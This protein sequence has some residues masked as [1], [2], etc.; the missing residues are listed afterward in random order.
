VGRL[1]RTGTGDGAGGTGG[2]GGPAAYPCEGR[3][4]CEDFEDVPVG[5]APGAPWEALEIKG[6]V[7]V[8]D[9]RAFSG[10][11]SLQVSIQATAPDENTYRRA[12][13]AISG[14]PLIPLTKNT[15][16]GRFMLFTDRI[17]DKTVHWNIARGAGVIDSV[18]FSYSYGGMGKL[19]ASYFGPTT[20][21]VTDC[22]QTEDQLV[23]TDRWVCIGFEFDGSNDEM[24]FWLD[25]TEIPELHV[26][27]L[28]K[29]SATCTESAIDGKWIAPEFESIGVGWTS[30]HHDAAGAHDAWIDDVIL[31]DEPIPCP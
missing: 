4:V 20:P 26:V 8:D 28:D 14:P 30:V 15:V 11:H 18:P 7:L 24:R 22:W 1:G 3:I 10:A 21:L 31:D 17:P 25:G 9:T 16:F 19:M 29:T 5:Q 12:L 27:G 2:I 6:S 13:L 23:P